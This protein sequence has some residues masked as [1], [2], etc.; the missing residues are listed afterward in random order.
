MYG[1]LCCEAALE[2]DEL[3]NRKSRNL[4]RPLTEES[5][6]IRRLPEARKGYMRREGALFLG[7]SAG[8]NRVNNFFS[9]LV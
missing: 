7:Y 1:T 2:Q 5:L 6:N 8:R 4:F 9:Q 3:M